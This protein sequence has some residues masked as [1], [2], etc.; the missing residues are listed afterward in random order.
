MY[1]HTS[2]AFLHAICETHGQHPLS[3]ILQLLRH[4]TC[5]PIYNPSREKLENTT[6]SPAD[7]AWANCSFLSR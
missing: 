3:G 7:H 2:I 4:N 1:Y 6:G 5:K